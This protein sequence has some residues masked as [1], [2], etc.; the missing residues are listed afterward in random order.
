MKV[1]IV[2]EGYNY[3]PA[4]TRW[5]YLD[6]TLAHEKLQERRK[7]VGDWEQENYP[8][9]WADMRIVETED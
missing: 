7:L 9:D 4:F 8:C 6:E 1:Y 2:E 3:E 5:Y